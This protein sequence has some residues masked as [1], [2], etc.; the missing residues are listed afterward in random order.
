MQ[1]AEIA[2]ILQNIGDLLELKGESV[3][4]VRA[5]Q[6]AARSVESYP[7]EVDTLADDLGKLRGI[8]GVGKEIALKIQ[9]L[10][11]TGRL[12]YYESLRAGLPEGVTELLNVPGIGPKTAYRLA[13]ELGVKDIQ[14]LQEALDQGLVAALP[15][16]GEKSA[17][18]IRRNLESLRRKDARM[19][20]GSALL[21]VEKI[22]QGLRAESAIH[23]LTVAGS[24][25]RFRETV[26]DVDLVCTS[27]EPEKA[28]R[29]FVGLPWVDRVLAE[30]TTKASVILRS[31][32]QAD[33]RVLEKER[34]GTLLQY[35]TGSKEH[36]VLL[37]ER[38]LRMGLSLS[39]LAIVR[40]EDNGEE[41][42]DNEE[43]VYRRLGLDWI[44]PELREQRGEIEAAAAGMLPTLVTL[45]DIKGDLHVH[46]DWSDGEAS[47]AVMVEEAARRGYAY[48]CITDHS[49]GRGIAHG[50]SFD[51]LKEQRLLIEQARRAHP[52]LVVLHGSEVDIRSDGSLDYPDDVLAWLDYAIGS[53]H[54]AMG[55]SRE[56]MTERIIRAMGNPYITVIG[57]LTTR[58]LGE[59]EPVD[60]DVE[61]VFRAARK[62]GTALEVNASP[63]RLDLKDSHIYRAREIGVPLIINT[64]AHAPRS[65]DDMRFGVA[66]ARRGWCRAEDILNAREWDAFSAFIA[67]K[68]PSASARRRAVS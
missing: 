18:N 3:F 34:F 19:P 8:P 14:Q 59:R 68:R 63:H 16:M 46:T 24:I 22:L 51:R 57:H 29:A 65:L 15:R 58:L 5:Y 49:V 12:D 47:V 42:Y 27:E 64:D 44:P 11:T 31:G 45:A 7:E 9:E 35:F 41:T 13:S 1:N 56:V 2:E 66:V 33:F 37:R 55:Q 26:G 48:V 23:D 4:K 62:T 53:I 6:R 21:E 40:L 25:R 43:G 10:I 39:D 52:G 36:N 17:D 20:L 32:L 61:R 60:L 28:I 54:S 67:A 50:L 30:G 38:A